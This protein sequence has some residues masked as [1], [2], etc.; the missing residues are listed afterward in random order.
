MGLGKTLQI[1][2]FFAYLKAQGQPS[3]PHLVVTSVTALQKW[4]NE[5]QRFTPQLSYCRISGS[6]AERCCSMSGE[7]IISDRRDIYLTTHETIHTE[8]AFLADAGFLWASITVDEGQ[9]TKIDKASLTRPLAR[10]SCP[11]RLLLTRTPVQNNPHELFS[12]FAYILPDLFTD[13]ALL[14]AGDLG[15]PSQDGTLC[16]SARALLDG[17]LLLRRLKS[18][19]ATDLPP[20]LHCRLHAPLSALQRRWYRLL[21]L[22]RPDTPRALGAGALRAVIASL[23]R[24]CNHPKQLVLARDA[25]AAALGPPLSRHAAARGGAGLARRRRAPP[26]AASGGLAA[27]REPAM[28]PPLSEAARAVEDPDDLSL[29]QSLMELRG[30]RG[31][32]LVRISGKP[33]FPARPRGISILKFDGGRSG[34]VAP[35]SAL[36]GVLKPHLC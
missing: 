21:L 28:E 14:H 16:A 22:R 3:G 2:S 31:E 10:I 7:D 5:I 30:I 9:P 6:I 24:V 32:A 19:V 13:S 26:R 11:F 29:S 23:R 17:C 34:A 35:V 33:L 8:E 36:W 20:K 15:A 4:T 12:L 27:G 1:L 18:H 25:D